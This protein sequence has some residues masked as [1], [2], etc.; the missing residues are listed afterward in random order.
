MPSSSEKNIIFTNIKSRANNKDVFY[1]K[2]GD[3]DHCQH[4]Y[5][6]HNIKPES[7]DTISIE[8]VLQ[9]T[10]YLRYLI[11]ELDLFLKVSGK[12]IIYLVN[13]G[14]HSKFLRSRSQIKY[15]FSLATNGRYILESKIDEGRISTLTYLKKTASLVEEDTIDKW[16]F[17]IISNGKKNPWVLDLIESIQGQGIPHYEVLIVGPSPYVDN[18]KDKPKEVKILEDV[19]LGE[20]KRPPISHKK[21]KIITNAMFNNLCILHD[22]YLLP[23]DWFENF[24]LYG[25]YFDILCQKTLNL[26]GKRYGVDWM[27]FHYPITTRFKLNRALLYSEWS[28][29]AIIPGGAIIMKKN[30]I[31]KFLLDERLF[32]DEM[33][34]F[35]L[36]KMANL[37]GL[38][39]SLDK[40]NH[41][42]SREVRHKVNEINWYRLKVIERYTH[43]KAIVKNAILFQTE[44]RKFKGRKK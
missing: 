11:K 13:T 43:I 35:Q 8:F 41:L 6:I 34:D 15:E 31:E 27:E 33:E 10:K 7:I 44:R 42:I 22:R 9:N 17:G 30:L 38:S 23:K 14:G 28:P 40:N 12:F 32:W 21:N 37:N 25:N 36:S 2:D 5:S 4:L 29:E 18:N 1:L 26:E 39:I 20:E 3:I 16:T 24:K 19:I